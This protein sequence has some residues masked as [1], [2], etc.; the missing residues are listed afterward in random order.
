MAP[1]PLEGGWGDSGMAGLMLLVF[2]LF[3]GLAVLAAA[4][5]PSVTPEPGDLCLLYGTWRS[6]RG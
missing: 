1:D 4:E 6:L 2:L 3:P 5:S